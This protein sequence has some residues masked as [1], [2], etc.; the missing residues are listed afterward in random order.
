M[1]RKFR[2]CHPFYLAIVSQ[3]R[4]SSVFKDRTILG[5][6]STNSREWAAKTR[7]SES[8]FRVLEE[9]GIGKIRFC[10]CLRWRRNDLGRSKVSVFSCIL[11]FK[12]ISK[13]FAISA[14]TR[15]VVVFLEKGYRVFLE[16][17]SLDHLWRK[18]TLR[19]ESTYRTDLHHFLS[20]WIH[21]SEFNSSNCWSSRRFQPQQRSPTNKGGGTKRIWNKESANSERER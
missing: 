20:Q 10:S 5:H 11:D 1:D 3:R 15:L 14:G 13:R 12:W 8:Y 4:K 21:L 17:E 9:I 19:Q 2:L 7:N 6:F 18:T 16:R